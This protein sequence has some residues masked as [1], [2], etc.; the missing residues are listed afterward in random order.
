MPRTTYK[1][2]KSRKGVG[3]RG[4]KKV[5]QGVPVHS[6]AS[7]PSSPRPRPTKASSSSK[8]IDFS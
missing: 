3:G 8:K 7:V 4:K 5:V 2:T 6:S 1:T